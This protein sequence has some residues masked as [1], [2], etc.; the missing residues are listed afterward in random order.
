MKTMWM[1][2]EKK[3]AAALFHFLPEEWLKNPN[4]ASK[5]PYFKGDN[6]GFDPESSRFGPG[7]M[8]SFT[9]RKGSRD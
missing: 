8:C 2:K 4:L 9:K 7:S 5:V 1:V 3:L 6:R